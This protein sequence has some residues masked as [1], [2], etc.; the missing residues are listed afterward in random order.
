MQFSLQA[1]MSEPLSEMQFHIDK[2]LTV[3]RVA[4]IARFTGICELQI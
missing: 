2:H 4:K 1:L 3:D